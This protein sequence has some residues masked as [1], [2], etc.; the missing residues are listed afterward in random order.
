MGKTRKVRQSGGHPK[1]SGGGAP[2]QLWGQE[3]ESAAPPPLG[4]NGTP[5]QG[6]VPRALAQGELRGVATSPPLPSPARTC[7]EGA[8]LPLQPPLLRLAFS[9]TF[10]ASLRS[11]SSPAR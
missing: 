5:A 11:P 10:S 3:T 8:P 4:E 7:R 9:L 1:H 6:G 2:F